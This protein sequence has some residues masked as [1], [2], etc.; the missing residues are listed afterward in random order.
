MVKSRISRSNPALLAP[1]NEDRVRTRNLRPRRNRGDG[2]TNPISS[3]LSIIPI[4]SIA[5]INHSAVIETFWVACV[6]LA[7][8]KRRY[9]SSRQSSR[10]GVVIVVVVVVAAAAIL[11]SIVADVFLLGSL[12]K[13][14]ARLMDKSSVWAVDWFASHLRS[15]KSLDQC[16]PD[17]K[18]KE[19]SSK[20]SSTFEAP[21]SIEPS[22]RLN[23][24]N[25]KLDLSVCLSVCLLG[26]LEL[27]SSQRGWT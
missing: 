6:S 11:K 20:Q 15:S 27:R 18:L 5:A 17:E 4:S 8:R 23:P 16:G 9:S 2:N 3:L 22:N 21:N 26:Q 19:T 1:T 14:N 12:V 10:S 7:W 25:I 24:N 13:I